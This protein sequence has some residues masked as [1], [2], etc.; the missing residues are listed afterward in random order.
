MTDEQ[1]KLGAETAPATH[2][3]ATEAQPIET[4][5]EDIEAAI[6]SK[7]E[8]IKEKLQVDDEAFDTLIKGTIIECFLQLKIRI[9]PDD[10][11]FAILLSQKRVMDYYSIL[12][13]NALKQLPRDISNRIDS[14]LEDAA[15]LTEAFKTEL[16]EF[17]ASFQEAI[18]S[19]ARALNNDIVASF[20]NFTEKKIEELKTAVNSIKA[21]TGSATTSTSNG[22]GKIATIVIIALLGLNIGL[23][24]FNLTKSNSAPQNV[25]VKYQK[26]LLDGFAQVRK[27]INPKDA[28][29]VEK[30]VIDAIDQRLRGKE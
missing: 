29:K 21:P 11:I 9:E 7:R 18:N 8:A 26:G 27:T 13:A 22:L 20:G 24:A 15:D 19:Q 1:E 10:P 14:K 6:E 30:I 17:K 25:E 3:E 2:K 16:E 28:E 23:S 4:T 12:I 5:R